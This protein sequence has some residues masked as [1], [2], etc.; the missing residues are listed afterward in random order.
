MSSTTR[1]SGSR[2][3]TRRAILDAA[4]T[5]LA[6][7]PQASLAEVA[8]AAEVGRST[9]HRY[10]PERTELLSAVVEDSLAQLTVAVSTAELHR[11]TPAE[12]L[13][14]ITHAYFELSPVLLVLFGEHLIDTR[15][16]LIGD[17]DE[18]DAPVFELLE[19]GQREGYFD[20]GVSAEWLNRVLWSVVYTGIAACAEGAMTRHAALES[21]TRTVERGTR[22]D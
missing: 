14:R 20:N 13:R 21:I 3:R 4:I 15:K 19:R 8:E 16:D 5:L 9:L 18:V 6:T 10:F 17:L 7:R 11:G 1:E 2:N 12:A 22:A